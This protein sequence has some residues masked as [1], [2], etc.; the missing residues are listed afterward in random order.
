MTHRSPPAHV[1]ANPGAAAPAAA[2]ARGQQAQPPRWTPSDPATVI[3]GISAGPGFAIGAL[4]VLRAAR[5]EVADRPG[6]TV[7]G[8]RE[9]EVAL[10]ATAEELDQLARDTAARVGAAEGE[11][12]VAQRELL[13]DAELLADTS[14]LLLDGHGV[15]WSWHRATERHAQRLAALPDALLAA[16]A[17]DLRDVA[18]R[19]LKH[20]GVGDAAKLHCEAPSILIAEDLTPS[21]T[22]TLDPALTHGFCTVSGG[23]TSHTAILA[24]TLGLP[25]AVA[26]GPKLLELPDGVEAVLDG[27]A[28]RLYACVSAN[29]GER[30]RAAQRQFAE[31]TQRNAVDRALP[32]MTQDG[33]EIE[34][35]ANVTRAEQVPNALADG[36]DGIGL[37]RTEFL[38]LQRQNAPDEEEQYE[39]Y[40]RMVDLSDGRKLIIRTLDIGADK[41]P[42]YLN[43]PSEAN[44]FLGMRGL[45]LCLRRPDLF[46]PQLRALYRAARAGPLWIMFPMVSTIE[47]A[48]QALALAQ[49]VRME[50]DAPKVPLGIMIETPSAA[51][52]ADRFAPR[53]DFFSIGTNDLTQYV[54]AIDREHPALARMADS[55]HPA[56]L[57]LIRQSVEGAR[58]HGRWV[59]VCGALA[60][61]PFGAAILTGLDVDGLSMSPH[62]I[63]A[64]KTRLRGARIDV[65][66]AL[67]RRALDCDDVNAVRALDGTAIEAA[68]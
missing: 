3:E 68:T 9:F 1:E 54:L 6:D 49:S 18:R 62:D 4:R 19:L 48:R 27:S 47:E 60:G 40:R 61:D 21:D 51:V 11:I 12:F 30:A 24:R 38:F 50:L 17:S 58:R 26:C 59:G 52:L 8:T 34:I 13:N 67:A 44:P 22:A 37:M 42:P 56:V 14:R 63:A 25:A 5:L 55:L 45:R 39:C 33:H 7:A 64:V 53:V 36:A 23:P 66:R 32:A 10:R 29:D 43:L 35:G 28:G 46:V 65:L 15:A 20:L 31:Q 41:R 57:R 2:R 16:R